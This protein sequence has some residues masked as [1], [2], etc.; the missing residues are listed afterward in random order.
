MDDVRLI[1]IA[2]PNDTHHSLAKQCLAANRDLVIDKPFATTLE[3]AADLVDFARQQGRLLTVYQNRR[4]DGDFQ[5]TQQLVKDRTLGRIVHFETNYDRFRPEFRPTAWRERSGP[6]SGILF[7]LGPHLLDHALMLFG[8]PDAVTADVRME[9]DSAVT[10]DAFDI[11]LRYPNNMTA[12]LRSSMLA[13]AERPRFL[14]H[15]TAG[16]FV[17]YGFDPQESNLRNGPIPPDGQW[18]A[19]PEQNW[20]VLTLSDG[21]KITQ[22]RIPPGP[23]DY[24]NYYANVRDALLG[25]AKIDVTS[26]HALE[27]MRGLE[28]AR[29]SSE[30]R[31]TLPWPKPV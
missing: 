16:A 21:T 30:R 22:R 18:S 6:G 27:V 17:K 28:L 13:A 11:T 1:V 7:D 3:E 23:G 14:L 12:L 29:E 19:E 5:S 31:C 25:H 2:T 10:D 9:R 26:Q 4:Y 20:G 8:L 24:R 15:G